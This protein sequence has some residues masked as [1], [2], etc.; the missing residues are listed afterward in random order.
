MRPKNLDLIRKSRRALEALAATRVQV[1]ELRQGDRPARSSASVSKVPGIAVDAL[2]CIESLTEENAELRKQLARANGV[3]RDVAENEAK[4]SHHVG[5]LQQYTQD[6]LE[7]IVSRMDRISSDVYWLMF[8]RG[9]GSD[10][11]PFLEFCGLMSKYVQVCRAAAK[12][13]VQF[14]FAN[15]HTGMAL[16]METYDVDYLAEKFACIFGPYFRAQPKMADRFMRRV[17]GDR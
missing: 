13:G 6:E 10:A 7:E 8:R 9:I 4:Q 14:P 12:K 11:P 1:A 17:L 16:P 5:S 2:A 15:E 3:A